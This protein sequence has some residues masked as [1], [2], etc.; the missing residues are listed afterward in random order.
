[1]VVTLTRQRLVLRTSKIYRNLK[2]EDTR[3]QNGNGAEYTLNVGG[4]T[5][6]PVTEKYPAK[7]MNIP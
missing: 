2:G 1:M 6:V 7:E 3:Y 5:A 4:D